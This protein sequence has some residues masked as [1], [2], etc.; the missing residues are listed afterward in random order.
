L[1][2]NNNFG[3]E[4]Q[5][6]T[7]RCLDPHW[8]S[9]ESLEGRIGEYFSLVLVLEYSQWEIQKWRLLCLHFNSSCVSA[10]KCGVSTNLAWGYPL[11]VGNFLVVSQGSLQQSLGLEEDWQ[12]KYQWEYQTPTFSLGT[13]NFAH[14]CPLGLMSNLDIQLLL[15]L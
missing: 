4:R 12:W 13:P 11:V 10:T 1:K 6:Q 9:H 8:P 3:I 14:Q 7:R 2:Y 5:T 15:L